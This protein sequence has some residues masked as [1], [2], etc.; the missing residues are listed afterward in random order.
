MGKGYNNYMCKKPFHPGSKAN[1]KRAWMAEQKTENEKKKQEDLKTQ[2]EKEQ[3]LYNNKA[4]ISSE[5]KDKLQLNFMYEAPPGAKRERQKEDDE[6][7][8]KFEWQRKYN[9]PREDYA[10]GNEDI[11]DQP[12]GIPVRNVRCIKCHKWGHINTDR[13]CPLFM[14]ASASSMPSTSMDPMELMRQ[15]RE[16]GFGLKENVLGH[17]MNPNAA[18]QQFIASEESDPETEFLKSLSTADKKKLLRKLKKLSKKQE[19]TKKKKS[20][21][22]KKTKVKD[23]SDSDSNLEKIAK[24]KKSKH[25]KSSSSSS[26]SSSDESTDMRERSKEK[27]GGSTS[28]SKTKIYETTKQRKHEEDYEMKPSRKQE[29][30][31]KNV[32]KDYDKREKEKDKKNKEFSANEKH[33]TKSSAKELEKIRAGEVDMKKVKDNEKRSKYEEFST[34]QKHSTKSST[35]NSGKGLME[36]D[37]VKEVKDKYKKTDYEES[38][39]IHKGST[40]RSH[41]EK[42]ST[43]ANTNVIQSSWKSSYSSSSSYSDDSISGEGTSSKRKLKELSQSVKKIKVEG[44]GSVIPESKKVSS[45][46]PEHPDG[47]SHTFPQA[48]V[49]YDYLVKEEEYKGKIHDEFRNHFREDRSPSVKQKYNN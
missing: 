15:M 9:A 21:K 11:K 39:S 38:S 3:D 27:K 23:S 33:S 44:S 2:Y 31:S 41:K 6:P 17:Q 18:N 28:K 5:S 26:E 35:K 43:T 24:K 34:G 29:T 22:S 30:G 25:K 1:I 48:K 47:F 4:M 13:E 8:Y 7:E 16:D 10:R 12:F 20:K 45:S 32:E 42:E 36:K 49:A 37:D 14:Q 40:K 46:E 19:K